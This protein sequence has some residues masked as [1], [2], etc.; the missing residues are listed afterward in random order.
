MTMIALKEAFGGDH[1][2]D[3]AIVL[4]AD[5]AL[6]L[7]PSEVNAHLHS[8]AECSAR[9]AAEVSLS[10]RAD[11]M[12]R[13]VG[14]QSVPAHTFPVW[15][16]AAALALAALGF[17]PSA[18]PTA[19]AAMDAFA[20]APRLFPVA[21]DSLLALLRG[22]SGATFTITALA[23]AAVLAV[24]GFAIARQARAVQLT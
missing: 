6:D 18:N 16:V 14:V 20:G 9:V 4:V 10:V 22:F 1:L 17:V 2:T 7:V 11:T 21:V 5:G 12:M 24:L 15:L 23:S 3:I 13:A 19:R 8:C